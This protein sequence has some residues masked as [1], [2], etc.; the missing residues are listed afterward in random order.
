MPRGDVWVPCVQPRW[1][2]MGADLAPGGA[3]V[4]SCSS[5]QLPQAQEGSRLHRA[6]LRGVGAGV[7]G[8]PHHWLQPW[9]VTGVRWGPSSHF[10]CSFFTIGVEAK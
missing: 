10:A 7:Q 5:L 2:P 4:A 6:A 8:C 3:W 9:G 1:A